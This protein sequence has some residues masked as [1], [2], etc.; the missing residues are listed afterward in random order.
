MGGPLGGWLWEGGLVSVVMPVYNGEGFIAESIG[1]VASTLS[2]AGVPFEVVVVD[3]G[4]RDGTL[5]RAV[6]AASRHRNVRVVGYRRNLGKGAAFIRG[7]RASRGDVVVLLDADLDVPPEQVLLLLRVMQATGAD[8]VVTDKWHP[9]SRTQATLL[10][11]LLSRGFN[12]LTRLLTGLS[13]RDTQTGAKAFKRRVLEDVAPRLY[14]KRYAFDVELLLLAAKMGYKI[15][16]APSLAEV[17]LTAPFKPREIWRMLLEL[18]S[19][20][21][22]HGRL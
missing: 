15:A 18:L 5:R 11:W 9:L 10:R 7:F 21:Y 22:R 19:I 20:A 2:G 16:E 12:A 6:E 3:D 1:R 17:R 13:L 8:V 14:A 4:S